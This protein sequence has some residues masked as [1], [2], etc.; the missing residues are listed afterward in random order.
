MATAESVHQLKTNWNERTRLTHR[1]IDVVSVIV[2]II[3]LV[4]AGFNGKFLGVGL[5]LLGMVAYE[6]SDLAFMVAQDDL[7]LLARL[8]RIEK[9][10]ANPSSASGAA[11]AQGSAS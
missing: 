8:E 9:M 6:I 10:L 2:G 5:M 4:W 3:L 7:E 11:P 1:V